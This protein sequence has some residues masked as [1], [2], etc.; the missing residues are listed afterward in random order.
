MSCYASLPNAWHLNFAIAEFFKLT[1]ANWARPCFDEIDFHLSQVLSFLNDV[2]N[3]LLKA[4][5]DPSEE[6]P[7]STAFVPNAIF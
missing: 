6:V 7:C 4:L 1:F 5:S 3:T 2:F